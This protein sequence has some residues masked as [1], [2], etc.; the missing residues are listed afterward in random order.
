MVQQWQYFTTRNVNVLLITTTKK[1]VLQI[2]YLNIFVSLYFFVIED[3]AQ[4][5]SIC[6]LSIYSIPVR[7][8]IPSRFTSL[9][10]CISW[11]PSIYLVHLS[12]STSIH[13]Y[14]AWKSVTTEISC[15][16]LLA[17]NAAN[18]Y[19]ILLLLSCIKLQLHQLIFFLLLLKLV[20]TSKWLDYNWDMDF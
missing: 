8:S 2:Y 15:I 3:T 9:H 20:T 11:S 10:L 1:E 18:P 14:N 19:Y 13:L 4:S 12:W 5:T 17:I 7:P 6:A 16:S